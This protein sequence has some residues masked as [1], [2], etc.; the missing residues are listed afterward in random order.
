[1]RKM[2]KTASIYTRVE[3]ELKEQ[4]EQIL[5]SLGIPMANAINLFLR[6]VVLQNGIPFDVKLPPHPLDISN[7]TKEEF[8]AE[9]QKGLDDVKAGRVISSA[10][11]REHMKNF[12]E[13]HKEKHLKSS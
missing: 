7:M 1:M 13:E 2:T 5:S 11:V 6:Q 8:D 4:V 10:Q 12:T 3:P 9:M